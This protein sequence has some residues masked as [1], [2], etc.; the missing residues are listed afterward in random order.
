MKTAEATMFV[1][2]S[3]M[4][5]ADVTVKTIGSNG[6]PCLVFMPL[7]EG[8]NEFLHYAL[9][10]ELLEQLERGRIRFYICAT[11]DD[12][13]DDNEVSNHE[14]MQLYESWMQFL[15][16]ELVPYI[17]SVTF[18]EQVMV[19]GI[20]IGAMHAMNL[21]LRIPE[22]IRKVLCLSGIYKI[23]HYIPYYY[24]ELILKNTPEV[25][26]RNLHGEK[27]KAYQNTNM[28]LCSGRYPMAPEAEGNLRELEEVLRL[29]DIPV[30]VEYWDYDAGTGWKWWTR[31]LDYFIPL[32]I[33]ST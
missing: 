8:V 19:C 11:C 25:I 12:V 27:V 3:N 30:I 9:S 5:H 26:L 4:L 21:Y 13:W 17:R 20:D 15:Q 1:L 7:H 29:K 28:V 10:S 2:H 18:M 23:S 6:V 24:D 33:G 32:L 31:Q 22:Y 14:K 16:Q